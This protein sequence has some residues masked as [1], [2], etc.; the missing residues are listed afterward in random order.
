[1]FTPFVHQKLTVVD[2]LALVPTEGSR[3][4]KF[5]DDEP[6]TNLH[7]PTTVAVT[8]RVLVSAA[9]A[10]PVNRTKPKTIVKPTNFIIIFIFLLF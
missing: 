6:L 2:A 3:L 7:V 4:P 1:V 8:V 9:N 5:S 10:T